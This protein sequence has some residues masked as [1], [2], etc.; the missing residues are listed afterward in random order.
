MDLTASSR[1]LPRIHLISKF[2][3]EFIF[4]NLT[5]NCEGAL[6]E[7]DEIGHSIFMCSCLAESDFITPAPCVSL[8]GSYESFND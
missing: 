5:K 4:L 6:Y 3:V 1:E 2:I 7:H 8:K